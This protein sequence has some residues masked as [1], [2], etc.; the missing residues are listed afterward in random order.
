MIFDKAGR[1]LSPTVNTG[2]SNPQSWVAIIGVQVSSAFVGHK[3]Q[4]KELKEEG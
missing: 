3:L 1:A 4:L 2:H